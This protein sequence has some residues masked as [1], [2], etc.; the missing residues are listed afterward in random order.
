M[1]N[2]S[3][4]KGLLLG[5][6][7]FVMSSAVCSMANAGPLGAGGGTAGD[8]TIGASTITLTGN[9]TNATGTTK[10]TIK[11]TGAG[12]LVTGA[13]TVSATTGAV[14]AILTAG[15]VTSA[16]TVTVS[17]GGTVTNNADIAI[18]IDHTMGGIVNYGT[19][20][21]TGG[22]ATVIDFANGITSSFTNGNSSGTDTGAV[23]ANGT[24]SAIVTAAAFT[25]NITN[26][27]GSSIV[28]AGNSANGVLDLGALI[29]GAVTNA[30]SIQTNAGGVA[31]DI[32]GNITGGLTNT[33]VI[34]AT[35]GT[36]IKTSGNFTD[37]DDGLY[38]NGGSITASTGTAVDVNNT[39]GLFRN[40]G[41]IDATGTGTAITVD[42]TI[43]TL[44]NTGT[45]KGITGG[46]AMKIGAAAGATITT[47]TNSNLITNAG[48]GTTIQVAGNTPTIGLT[49]N[50][51]IE[52]ST[53]IAIDV[54]S[55]VTGTLTNN[56]T[57]SSEGA[58]TIDLD[59]VWDISNAGT[60]S[61][62]GNFNTISIAD[63]VHNDVTNTGSITADGSSATID[64]AGTSQGGV[65]NTSGIIE[66]TGTGKVINVATQL[67]G[68]NGIITNGGTIRIT[69]TAS[70]A[71]V[72]SIADIDGTITNTGTISSAATGNASAIEITAWTAANLTSSN[73]INN[74]GLIRSAG[75]HAT[76]I[77][78]QS[79]IAAGNI[80]NTGTIQNT[81]T[82][83]ALDLT[84]ETAGADV[85][86][87]VNSGSI[88]TAS[89]TTTA[90][91]LGDI[92]VLTNTGSITGKVIAPNGSVETINWNGGTI[93]GSAIDLGGDDGDTINFG[94]AAS[95]SISYAGTISYDDMNVKFGTVR[96]TGVATG[97]NAGT[98]T[99]TVADGATLSVGASMAATGVRSIAGTLHVDAG[100][101]VAGTGA[102]GV[103]GSGTIEIAVASSASFGQVSG[104]A[105]TGPA[106]TNKAIS[107][108]ASNLTNGVIADGTT[109]QNVYT[110]T[111]ARVNFTD[112]A[113]ITDNSQRYK[114]TQVADADG[115]S[116]DVLVNVDKTIAEQTST[117]SGAA[118]SNQSAFSA[119]AESLLN[120]GGNDSDSV[121]AELFS[122]GSDL[123][124]AEAVEKLLPN[125]VASAASAAS[126]AV[127]DQAIGAIS[128][129]L[130]EQHAALD[131][132]N[133]G[134]ATGGAFNESGIWVK[135]FGSA[136][137]Q[138]DRDGI[139]GYEADVIGGAIGADTNV[140]D[141]MKLGLAFS[142][143]NTSADSANGEA[144][145]DSYMGT[146]YGTYDMGSWY[147]DGLL[148]FA[149][150]A[151]E[152]K[153]NVVVGAINDQAKGDF[154][155]Q[156]YT[157]KVEAGYRLN[158]EGGL[159]VTPVAGLRYT[160]LTTDQ[161]TETGST[162]NLTVDNDDQHILKSEI[163]TKL[164][165]PIV[166]GGLTFIP[167]ID[168]RWA[169]DFIGDEQESTSNFADAGGYVFTTKGADVARSALKLGLGVDVIAQDNFTVSFDY[170]WESKSNYDSHTGTVQ[171]RFSF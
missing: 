101:T 60:I 144:D 155:G 53:G 138:G 100:K 143:A 73:Y 127:V 46:V 23:S 52:S 157:A 87:V 36:A 150:N 163:G 168:V 103:T 44:T 104:A 124:T 71:D 10:N 105:L 85:I 98:S 30:G 161:Y 81:G 120:N 92:G 31:I 88:L 89:T 15:T 167:Q 25:G 107:I 56:G 153:R 135:G 51:T 96:L 119:M 147:T 2:F 145:V 69:N 14:N 57:I 97:V 149:Q 77:G 50:G 84:A 17:N 118:A 3:K 62:V 102:V 139:K 63:G 13:H 5:A 169:Y 47:F 75:A 129:R 114:F 39:I 59:A 111:G 170:D 146:L 151:Y 106:A 61:S 148:A 152:T 64:F 74:S 140:T 86:T 113:V 137:D 32:G 6:S 11:L 109:L 38:N 154:D 134:I 94:D 41:T 99:V 76:I 121:I 78:G 136:I 42:S 83:I 16:S 141:Q 117:V 49:N 65:V 18:N 48:S 72:L 7:A 24:G 128:D 54:D 29:T 95:D 28:S 26:Y 19:I 35:S 68:A 131:L 126:D 4:K 70:T 116:V 33:G 9:A 67:D 164:A 110:G 130:G 43:T 66:N 82:G 165:Y 159:Q 40:S 108:D 91:S 45:I 156:Q 112:G 142:Y 37:T 158:V 79:A 162:A 122:L 8:Y 27:T 20:S 12:G 58:I 166:E 90:V 125:E 132:G 1:I 160:M 115:F 123:E 21:T 80:T 93:T 171:A 22:N 34:S 133:K 55:N